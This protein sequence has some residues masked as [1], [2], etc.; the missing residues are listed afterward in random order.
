MS[1]NTQSQE[2]P[3]YNLIVIGA[4]PAGMRAAGTAANLGKKVLLLE[5]NK[6]FIS[7]LR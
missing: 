5:K 2:T 7:W 1:R 4:A 3:K 6:S